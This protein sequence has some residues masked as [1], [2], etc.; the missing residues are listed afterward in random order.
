MVRSAAV[1]LG[2]CLLLAGQV[3]RAQPENGQY[4]RIRNVNS[5]KLLVA[6]GDGAGAKIIQ[7]TAARGKR[8]DDSQ[9]W[10]LVKVIGNYYKLVNRTTGLVL[11]VPNGLRNPGVQIQ[12]GVDRRAR[13]QLWSLESVGGKTF[14]IKSLF[15][16]LVLD[17]EG[18]ERGDGV[19]IIQW[20]FNARGDRKNQR[21]EFLPAR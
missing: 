8:G 17:A 19:P 18:A 15:N 10:Q 6:D 2:G 1:A 16:G 7:A 4:Y 20:T 9:H 11:E 3:G 21:W 14:V 13:N 5:G 12:Q